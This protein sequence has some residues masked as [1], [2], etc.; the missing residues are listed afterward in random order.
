MAGTSKLP[1]PLDPKQFYILLALSAGPMHG[2]AIGRQT[3]RDSQ[4]ALHLYPA[5][6]YRLLEVMARRGLV[7]IA[8]AEGKRTAYRLTLAGQRRLKAE[9]VG[10]SDAAQAV[11]QRVP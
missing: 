4:N 2:Y 11:R 6:L 7:E 5:T 9:G 3:A 1:E 8:Y 10:W